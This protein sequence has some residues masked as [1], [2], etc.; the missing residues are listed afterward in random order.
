MDLFGKVVGDLQE[1]ISIN[2]NAITG[3][4]KY[5]SDYNGFSSKI[6][7]RS[8]NYLVLHA[9]VDNETLV[10]VTLTNPVVLD[11]DN[12]IV[13]RIADK[14]SQTVTV[15]AEKYGHRDNTQVFD[16]SGLICESSNVESGSGTDT[17]GD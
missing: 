16:L 17:S 3:T 14:D 7:E 11:N 13:L 12:V 8:G 10:T 4:L 1:N 6:E 2:G 15:V 9:D 5:V